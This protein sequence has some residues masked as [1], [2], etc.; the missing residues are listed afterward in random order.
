MPRRSTSIRTNR[1]AKKR[2]LRNLRI[3]QGVKKT[4]K[5]FHALI[6]AKN[7]DEAKKLLSNVFSLLDKAAKKGVIHP[8][9]ASRQKSRLSL[10]L[11]KAA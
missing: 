5:K 10:K 4:L 6:A 7:I 11:R 9:T 8:N 1:S 2:R 3:K